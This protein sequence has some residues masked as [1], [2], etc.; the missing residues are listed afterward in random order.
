LVTLP[1]AIIEPLKRHLE[2]VRNLHNK[3]LRDGFG[4]VYLPQAL[5]RKY[6]NAAK[7]EKPET[8][9]VSDYGS[10]S[11]LIAPLRSR[12]RKVAQLTSRTC[13]DD[14]LLSRPPVSRAVTA[15]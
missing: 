11:V 9:P 6:P 7:S 2:S 10:E 8:G 1:D 3:D 15:K 4:E 5:A 12:N 13:C 14:T